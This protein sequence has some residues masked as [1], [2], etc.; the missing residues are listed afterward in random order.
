[1]MNCSIDWISV[2]DFL[3]AKRDRERSAPESHYEGRSKRR[4]LSAT[5]PASFQKVC[6][7]S[8]YL[9][10]ICFNQW[11]LIRE[12]LFLNTKT[13]TTTTTTRSPRGNRSVHTQVDDLRAW[14]KGRARSELG[15]KSAHHDSPEFCAK[16]RC[17]SASSAV[18]SLQ[19]RVWRISSQGAAVPVRSPCCSNRNFAQSHVGQGANGEAGYWP[20]NSG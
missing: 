3:L 11:C 9:V 5:R 17:R 6:I 4:S 1:M 18:P 16:R 20:R 14:S 15:E 12:H 13:T 10:C 8:L 19:T 7:T 2:I